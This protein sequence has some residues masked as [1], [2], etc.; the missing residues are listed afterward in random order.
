M[1]YA[2]KILH[3]YKGLYRIEK[4]LK[5][6]IVLKL[7]VKSLSAQL[8][9]L[10]IVEG[11]NV[12]AMPIKLALYAAS[13]DVLKQAKKEFM[14]VSH[15]EKLDLGITLYV[16]FDGF[17]RDLRSF[18]IAVIHEEDFYS[19]LPKIMTML[20]NKSFQANINSTVVVGM[21]TLPVNLKNFMQ[22]IEKM[23][24]QEASLNI[25]ITKGYKAENIRNI[26]YFENE[27]RRIHVKTAFESYPTSLT[28][29]GVH[30]LTSTYSFASPYVSYVVNLGWVEKTSVRDVILKNQEIIPLSQKKAAQ[31]KQAYRS[32]MS[33]L[34]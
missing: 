13:A 31:F 8:T 20:Q 27:N 25:P 28:M 18:D 2:P 5:G 15:I 30:E 32:Y 3:H 21:F 23:P 29:K 9:A 16:G 12:K 6:Y 34:Q 33:N 7:N 17:I 24:K 26:I 4:L 22:I 1:S 19:E 14:K 11:G 10:K